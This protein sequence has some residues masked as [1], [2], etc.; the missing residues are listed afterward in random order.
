MRSAA[1]PSILRCEPND[2]GHL[3]HRLVSGGSSVLVAFLLMAP[4]VRST[5]GRRDG[6][7]FGGDTVSPHRL[8]LACCGGSCD[9]YWPCRLRPRSLSNREA[10]RQSPY[11]NPSNERGGGRRC[12]P[13]VPES[14]AFGLRGE[15]TTG[16]NS[17]TMLR[18]GLSIGIRSLAT[19]GPLTAARPTVPQVATDLRLNQRQ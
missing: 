17:G 12:D 1:Q 3:R 7:P 6:G 10:A 11:H 2:H 15:R 14:D 5:S 4:W 13:V 8:A 19:C 9:P 18:W 16:G